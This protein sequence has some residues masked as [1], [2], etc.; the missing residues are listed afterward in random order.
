MK[1]LCRCISL[2]LGS[3]AATP[4]CKPWPCKFCPCRRVWGLRR[5][6]QGLREGECL[7][8]AWSQA[9]FDSGYMVF[10]WRWALIPRL[11]GFWHTW[12]L[13]WGMQQR[14]QNS[15]IQMTWML[16]RALSHACTKHGVIHWNYKLIKSLTCLRLKDASYIHLFLLTVY[17]R[18]PEHYLCWQLLGGTLRMNAPKSLFIG[19]L[20]STRPTR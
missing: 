19:V 9:C 10:G 18:G 3:A 13:A 17:D 1:V 11:Q 4:S 7:G 15:V 16:R 12:Q 6:L 20:Q 5:A 14:I 2:H 8:A